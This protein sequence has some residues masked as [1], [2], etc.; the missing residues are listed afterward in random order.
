[1]FSNDL[2]NSKEYQANKAVNF[3]SQQKDD[4]ILNCDFV[5]L[6][7]G[8][9]NQFSFENIEI[10]E[11]SEYKWIEP[12]NADRNYILECRYKLVS[13]SESLDYRPS[14]YSM[15]HGVNI[16][17]PL[18][19]IDEKSN[20]LYLVFRRVMDIDV[21]ENKHNSGLLTTE[22]LDSLFLCD[23]TQF[24]RNANRLKQDISSANDFIKGKI[25]R[26]LEE[27]YTLANRKIS[28]RNA[29]KIS[30]MPIS[31]IRNKKI[32]VKVIEKKSLMPKA[33]V[34]EPYYYISNEDYDLIIQIINKC[35][36]QYE[37]TSK[38]LKDLDEED[39]RNLILG[40]INSNFNFA[41]SAE[42]FSNKGHTDIMIEAN[43]KAAFIAECKLWKGKSYVSSGID[44]LLSYATYKDGKLALLVFNKSNKDFNKVLIEMESLI[45]EHSMKMS[46]INHK[47]NLWQYKFRSMTNETSVT[48]TFIV[49]NYYFS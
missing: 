43:N 11:R 33:N 17:I 37:R 38:T 49:A 23:T 19:V 27:I 21:V 5:E 40:A 45:E 3:I 47:D 30:V 42:S 9:F 48:I 34:S 44:Q 10:D 32:E 18:R 20:Q 15:T 41:G 8:I 1:M 36:T 6:V 46:M 16:G 2:D 24:F 28:L 12:Q 7:E 25:Q 4:Y 13:G 35:M 29:L 26:K 14:L 31:D 39:I 22:N